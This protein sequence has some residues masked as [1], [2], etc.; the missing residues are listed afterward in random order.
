[1]PHE[2]DWPGLATRALALA[3]VVMLARLALAR[4]TAA[5][6]SQRRA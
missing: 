5:A 3:A 4:L 6:R 2:V 1:M